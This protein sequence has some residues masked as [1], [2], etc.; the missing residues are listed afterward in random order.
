MNNNKELW[1]GWFSYLAWFNAYFSSLVT[2]STQ[3]KEST[4]KITV[5][6][7]IKISSKEFFRKGMK[8]FPL[9]ITLIIIQTWSKINRIF[10]RVEARITPSCLI[11]LFIQIQHKPFNYS[12]IQ[13]ICFLLIMESLLAN[14]RYFR[15]ILTLF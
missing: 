8:I 6:Y 10:K 12:T 4:S 13:S 9:I 2:S 5:T 15:T 7:N 3:T 11:I 1:E 14:G